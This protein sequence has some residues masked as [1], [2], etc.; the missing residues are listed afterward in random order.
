MNGLDLMLDREAQQTEVQL[1]ATLLADTSLIFNLKVSAK[2]F[3]NDKNG[4]I[5]KV[6]QQLQEAG[7][8][9]NPISVG[10][11]LKSKVKLSELMELLE[12]GHLYKNGFYVLQNKVLEN[13]KAGICLEISKRI[14]K[15]LVEG[16]TPEAIL[17]TITN[18]AEDVEVVTG[19]AHS[20]TDVMNSTIDKIEQNYK[21]GGRITGMVTGYKR[22]DAVLNG[23]EKQKYIIIGGRPGKGK[24]AFSLELA[25][26]LSKENQVLF[27]SLE[28]AMQELGERLLT[29]VN[30]MQSYKVRTGNLTEEELDRV[31]NGAAAISN[32]KLQVDDTE[33]L[34]VEELVRRSTIHKNKHGLDVV[35]VDYLTLL[36][37]EEKHKD[38]RERVNIISNKLRQMSKKLDIAVICLCQLSRAVEARAD[39]TPIMADLKES[40]N[41]EQDANIILFL[42]SPEVEEQEGPEPLQVIIAKNRGGEANKPINFKYYKK[43]QI[44]DEC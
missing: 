26:R 14:N 7:E 17:T 24:T 19:G 41:I 15:G 10:D 1:I 36:S 30:S 22:L 33:S 9:I 21:R 29:N 25:K 34:S 4:M 40:G 23:F 12:N 2:H 37:T 3:S 27:F 42:H 32:L 20:I 38:I 18:M 11:K 31:M 43:T 16:E 8:D 6:M 13:Y 39:K 44:I 5:I 28:M 35:I